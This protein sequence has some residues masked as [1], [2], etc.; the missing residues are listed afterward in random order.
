[1]PDDMTETEM[2]S[3]WIVEVS[4]LTD[5]DELDPE[6]REPDGVCAVD[7][8]WAATFAEPVD[9]D[10]V[11]DRFHAEVPIS[12]LEDFEI[13]PRPR[14]GHDLPCDIRGRF[15][16]GAEKEVENRLQTPRMEDDGPGEP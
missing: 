7:G 5:H 4:C 13:V 2:R 8:M 16:P 9:Q 11:L 15:G 1:M 6:D 12:S 10:T 3:A 14:G